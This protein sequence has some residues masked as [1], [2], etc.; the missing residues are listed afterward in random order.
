MKS[1]Q[2]IAIIILTGL[3]SQSCRKGS[4]WGIR[5]EG[6]SVTES[7]YVT[8]F[9]AINLSVNADISYMQD[10]VYKLEITG[11]RNILLILDTKTEGNDLTIDFK[12]NVWTYDKLKLIIHSP[13][14]SKLNISGSGNIDVSNTIT[15]NNLDLVISGSGNIS[16]PAVSLQSLSAKISG[17]GDIRVHGGSCSSEY[18][19]I[20]GSGNITCD[21]LSGKNGDIKM[22]GSGNISTNCSETLTVKI[23]GSGN[24]KYRGTPAINSDISGNGKLIHID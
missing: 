19:S 18:L 4:M 13:N 24:V 20:S 14:L 1:F 2:F 10:S 22:S 3:L 17:S 15:G 21:F 9:S 11:Q 8:G 12:R 6:S 16:V 23:S 5:G 7:R